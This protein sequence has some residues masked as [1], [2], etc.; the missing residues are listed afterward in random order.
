MSATTTTTT[1]RKVLPSGTKNSDTESAKAI[2]QQEKILYDFE[3]KT[4]FI[5]DNFIRFT[6]EI[7]PKEIL[8]LPSGTIISARQKE[9]SL[10]YSFQ[11]GGCEVHKGDKIYEGALISKNN[12]LNGNTNFVLLSLKDG[13]VIKINQPD[14]IISHQDSNKVIANPQG[15]IVKITMKMEEVLNTEFQH[16]I[17]E[18]KGDAEDDDRQPGFYIEQ[19]VSLENK[20]IFNFKKCH[21][22]EIAIPASNNED[23][24]Q[25]PI[26]KLSISEIGDINSHSKETY[27]YAD[28]KLDAPKFYTM[29]ST[30]KNDKLQKVIEF[31]L[32]S[33]LFPGE[34]IQF[35]S[36][37][38]P[39]DVSYVS[40]KKSGDKLILSRGITN[41]I[42]IINSSYDNEKFYI[43]LENLSSEDEDIFLEESE[44]INEV[45]I[46]K[47]KVET[48]IFKLASGKHIIEG[49][50]LNLE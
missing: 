40:F 27:V 11:E 1:I 45:Q 21:T 2:N 5:S 36:D 7:Q 35:D 34:I 19:A 37:G 48:S 24:I 43:E 16:I 26:E 15:P 49:K 25:I 29:I 9:K 4:L 47:I 23:D 31:T 10:K 18:S 22:T 50:Y 12:A 33:N 13:N 46:D 20:S 42:T 39:I 6:F 44:D 30:L 14:K 8:F 28:I 17:R 3:V 38:N 32:P 41:H